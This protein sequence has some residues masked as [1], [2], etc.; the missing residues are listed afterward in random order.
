MCLCYD[1]TMPQKLK[2]MWLVWRYLGYYDFEA[3]KQ[4]LPLFNTT[5]LLRNG[6]KL[7]IYGM[8][9]KEEGRWSRILNFSRNVH[10]FP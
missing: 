8:V 5:W 3:F 1:E 2:A 10:I 6:Q 7:S 4:N 9:S